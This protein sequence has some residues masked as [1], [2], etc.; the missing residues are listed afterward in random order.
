MLC[1]DKLSHHKDDGRLLLRVGGYV[2]VSLND[3]CG[4]SRNNR[5]G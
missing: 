5:N 1:D 3:G 2:L 4:R